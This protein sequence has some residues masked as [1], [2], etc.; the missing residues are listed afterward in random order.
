MAKFILNDEERCVACRQCMM[1][2]AMAHTEADTLVEAIGLDPLPQPR[3]HVVPRGKGGTPLQCR[4]CEGDAPCM[5]ICPVDAIQRLV[6][7]GPVILNEEECIGCKRCLS[8]CPFGAIYLPRGE[9]KIVVKC[10]LCIVRTEAGLDPACVAGCPTGALQFRDFDDEGLK[11]QR[12]ADAEVVRA[13]QAEAV[14]EGKS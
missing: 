7:D 5:T 13:A 8:A 14:A 12:A 3:M 6:P 10:D 2:C 11:K 4:H 1:D 9:S